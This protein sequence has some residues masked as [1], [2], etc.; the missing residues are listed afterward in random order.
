LISFWQTCPKQLLKKNSVT[1]SSPKV[2]ARGFSATRSS[3]ATH[4]CSTGMVYSSA[5]KDA[6]RVAFTFLFQVSLFR[7]TN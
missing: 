4:S 6:I 1:Y 5:W 2:S 7:F 3:N